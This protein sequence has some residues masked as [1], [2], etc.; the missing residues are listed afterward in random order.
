MNLTWLLLSLLFS[1][2]GMGYLMYGKRMAEFV[3][4]GVGLALM[5]VPYFISSNVLMVIVCVALM[6]APFFRRES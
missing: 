4:V 1:V 5:V 2:I 6:A 3:P